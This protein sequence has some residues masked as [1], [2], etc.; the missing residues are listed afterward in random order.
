VA[1]SRSGPAPGGIGLLTGRS[2]L[3]D[4]RPAFDLSLRQSDAKLLAFGT[5]S[6]GTALAAVAEAVDFFHDSHEPFE[7]VASPAPA[8]PTADATDRATDSRRQLHFDVCT[9]HLL[10]SQDLGGQRESPRCIPGAG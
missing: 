4:G 10:V 6:L 2:A 9:R 3:A 1:T 5:L 8:Q 7:A